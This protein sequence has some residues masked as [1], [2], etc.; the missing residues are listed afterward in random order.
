MD[1]FKFKRLPILDTLEIFHSENEHSYFPF[2]FHDVFC[3]SLITKGIEQFITKEDESF[4]L[5]GNIS[6]TNPGEV[7]RNKSAL[8]NGYSYKT[9]YISPDLLTYLN[10][11]RHVN[12]IQRVINNPNLFNHLS[13]LIDMENVTADFWGKSIALLLQYQEKNTHLHLPVKVDRFESINELIDQNKGE[14]IC[15]KQLCSLFY[16][17]QYHFIRE[18]K[19]AKGVSPQTFI[20][21]K[22]LQNVKKDVLKTSSLK[23]IAW[24]NGFYDISHLNYSFKKFFGVSAYAYINSNILH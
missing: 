5:S 4:A 15:T 12:K 7:H 22:R 1:S 2:H 13:M 14:R 17:S 8:S 11:G 19:R 6:I 3:I 18:F 10:G 16:M 23:D 9:I 20:M 24:S 21:L